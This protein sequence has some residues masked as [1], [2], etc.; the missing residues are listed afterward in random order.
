MKISVLLTF[1]VATALYSAKGDASFAKIGNDAAKKVA[2]DAVNDVLK[3]LNISLSVDDIMKEANTLG[4][5]LGGFGFEQDF[6]GLLFDVDCNIPEIEDF[7]IPKLPDV[8]SK[9][10]GKLGLK[11]ILS[12]D[13]GPCSISVSNPAKSA[14]DKLEQWCKNSNE[15]VK[16]SNKKGGKKT[17]VKKDN[18]PVDI[19]TSGEND[20]IGVIKVA[21]G[22]GDSGSSGDDKMPSGKTR[23][24]VRSLTNVDKLL[25]SNS[26]VVQDIVYNDDNFWKEMLVS[27][28]NKIPN[29]KVKDFLPTRTFPLSKD[30]DSYEEL[31]K[32]W[33]KLSVT[34]QDNAAMQKDITASLKGKYLVDSKIPD[35]KKLSELDTTADAKKREK[36]IFEYLVKDDSLGEKSLGYN[37]S[38]AVSD[39]ENKLNNLIT[40]L[41]KLDNKR[42][43]SPTQEYLDRL[44]P[45]ARLVFYKKAKIQEA[46]DALFVFMQSKIA[47]LQKRQRDLAVESA[48][49]CASSFYPEVAYKEVQSMLKS[50]H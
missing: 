13:V 22:S 24:E 50:I 39:D 41:K 17:T 3:N 16:I 46:K 11:S 34:K 35:V 28:L 29:A 48:A 31:K 38:L 37:I 18:T 9:I 10:D 6:L 15:T 23:S 33:A 19:I 32:G 21:T 26:S 40:I 20:N 7:K 30:I 5:K 8:C 1:F 2:N 45:E 36:K 25:E 4:G 43:T 27:Y 47:N 44:S 14:G 12:A 42:V 49:T